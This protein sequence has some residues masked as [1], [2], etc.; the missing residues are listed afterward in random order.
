M[1]NFWSLWIIILT[2]VTIVGVTWILFANRKTTHTGKEA[3]TG[4]V[5]DGIEEY[6]NPLPAW[7]LYMFVFTIVFGIG[8]LIAY[9]GMGS[10]P[11]LLGWSQTNQYEASV[12]KANKKY[13]AIY[14]EYAALSIDALAQ[15]GKALRMGQRLFANNCAQCH[16][17]AATGSYGFA[18]LTDSD[19]LYGG[20]PDQIKASITQGRQGLMP[21]W[22]AVIGEAGVDEV[23]N[24][25]LSLSNRKVDEQL[26]ATGKDKYNMFCASCHG[27]EGLGNTAMGAPNLADNIW[28]YG[29]SPGLVKR[30]IHFGRNGVMPA[31]GQLISSEKIHLLTAYVYSFSLSQKDETATVNQEM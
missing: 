14:A 22:G 30:S 20:T 28:L 23:A 1:S 19:W 10:F 18:N 13:G 21:A 6:D 3:K 15:N 5:Y 9:P 16:G 8:Y 31:H 27:V 29:G 17:S 25:V 2:T 11:G 24:Y 12:E 7:W 4:H 26:A